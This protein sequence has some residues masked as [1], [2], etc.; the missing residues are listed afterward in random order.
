M[1]KTILLFSICHATITRNIHINKFLDLAQMD[2]GS[3]DSLRDYYLSMPHH[4][5][6][7]IG[8]GSCETPCPF[9]VPIIERMQAAHE[10]LRQ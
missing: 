8:C 10:L 3:I 1:Q 4:A 9:K 2:S 6:E 7:C 5:D